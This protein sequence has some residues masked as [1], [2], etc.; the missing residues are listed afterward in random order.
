MFCFGQNQF[1]R[2]HSSLC[3]ATQ[4]GAPEILFKGSRTTFHNWQ[5]LAVSVYWDDGLLGAGVIE[6]ALV[7]EG[8][9]ELHVAALHALLETAALDVEAFAVRYKQRVAWLMHFIV[10]TDAEGD[11]PAM[12][13]LHAAFNAPVQCMLLVISKVGSASGCLHTTS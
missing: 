12:G 8:T 4:L 1:P 11:V 13:H 6:H 7:R 3:H 5:L 9:S 10:H 2:Q